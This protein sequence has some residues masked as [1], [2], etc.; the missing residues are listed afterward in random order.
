MGSSFQ[1]RKLGRL[2][3]LKNNFMINQFQGTVES[4]NFTTWWLCASQNEISQL[5]NVIC[6]AAMEIV[7]IFFNN[8]DFFCYWL[9]MVS[10]LLI[11]IMFIYSLFSGLFT[12]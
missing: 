5:P 1:S 6:Y 9:G 3:N 12:S 7:Q 4:L 2:K 11:E 8:C 10:L